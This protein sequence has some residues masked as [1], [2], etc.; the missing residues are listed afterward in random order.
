MAER[1]QHVAPDNVA[2]CCVQL[3]RSFGRGVN[4]AQQ[5]DYRALGSSRKL[6]VH[7]LVKGRVKERK[8]KD[9]VLS[10]PIA[11]K[12]KGAGTTSAGALQYKLEW[13]A[14]FTKS[15]PCKTKI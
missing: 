13:P 11:Q 3:L 10:C 15:L 6:G 8:A 4:C 12:L 9:K 14:N 2:R 5:F 7:M 1:A